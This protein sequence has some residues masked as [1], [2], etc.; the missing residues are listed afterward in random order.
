VNGLPSDHNVIERQKSEQV[1]ENRLNLSTIPEVDRFPV[2]ERMAGGI[3]LERF[4]PSSDIVL[5]QGGVGYAHFSTDPALDGW[6]VRPLAFV[7]SLNQA[8][9]TASTLGDFARAVVAPGGDLVCNPKVEALAANTHNNNS[10][11]LPK[12]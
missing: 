4:C 9:F 6:N 3:C 12:P 5:G 11:S 2:K 10:L 8:G 1:K 7:Q